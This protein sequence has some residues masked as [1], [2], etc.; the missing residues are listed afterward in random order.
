MISDEIDTKI[1]YENSQFLRILEAISNS[2]I[3]KTYTPELSN[4]H[5][6]FRFCHGIFF[7]Y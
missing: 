3:Y 7:I 6:I 2:N 4:Q 1:D 5:K